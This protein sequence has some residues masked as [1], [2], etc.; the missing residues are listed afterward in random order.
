MRFRL[1]EDSKLP[2]VV[3]VSLNGIT[4]LSVSLDW[5][6]SSSR[7]P[8]QDKRLKI[9][10]GKSHHKTSCSETFARGEEKQT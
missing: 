8:E 10:D 3:D 1:I 4:S 7:D 6:Q 2:V 5:L 9:M